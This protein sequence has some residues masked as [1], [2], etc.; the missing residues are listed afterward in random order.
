[1][2]KNIQPDT[3]KNAVI[4]LNYPV[5]L[6]DKTLDQVTMRRPS[7]GDLL[8]HEPKGSDDVITELT[9]IGLLCELKQ[10]EMRRLDSTDYA[11]LQDQYVRFRAVPGQKDN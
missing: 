3:A 6:A 4:T 7:M 1:M 5:Q 10:E 2:K 8:D 9:L 11:R